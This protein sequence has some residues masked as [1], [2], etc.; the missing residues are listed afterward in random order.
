MNKMSKILNCVLLAV[1]ILCSTHNNANA[2]LPIPPMPGMP[3]LDIPANA[4]KLISNI[5]SNLRQIQSMYGQIKSG[6]LTNVKIGGL[7]F[8]KL[9]DIKGLAEKAKGGVDG[10]GGVKG[11]GKG[12]KTTGK[13]I[14]LKAVDLGISDKSTNEEEYFNAFHTLFIQLP[15]KTS[16]IKDEYPI[17][18]S[19]Y[20]EKRTDYL[21]DMIVDTY[22]TAKK[23]EEMLKV[24]EKTI[25]RLNECQ[26][27]T[28]EGAEC[29]FWG[30]QVV[31]VD[32]EAASESEE[33]CDP[34]ADE[35]C[36]SGAV[37]ESMNAYIVS[38]VYDR[39]L[40]I[41]ED[42]T[43]MEAVYKASRELN[44][45]EPVAEDAEQSSSAEDYIL[46]GYKFAYSQTVDYTN[47]KINLSN[48][49][50]KVKRSDKCRKNGKGCPAV[51]KDSTETASMDSTEVYSK[52]Q[53]IDDLLNEAI[54]YHNLKVEL[55]KYKTAY[56]KYL[57]SKAIH[58]E[59]LKV[60]AKSDQCV[61]DFLNKYKAQD[62]K[63][64]TTEL[65]YGGLFKY[66]GNSVNNHDKRGGVSRKIIEAYQMHTTDTLIGTSQKCKGFYKNCPSGYILDKENSCE[67]DETLHPCI[68]DMVTKDIGGSAN[69][70]PEVASDYENMSNDGSAYDETDGLKDGNAVD[71][72]DKEN[73]K[74]S[75]QAWR[76][77][78]RAVTELAKKGVLNFKQW[79]DQKNIQ[80]EYLTNKYR[81][82]RMIIRSTDKALNSYKIGVALTNGFVSQSEP[83]DDLLK[84]I[85]ST[86]SVEEA[87]KDG[88]A[89]SYATSKGLCGGT[90][91]VSQ[92]KNKAVKNVSTSY[93]CQKEKQVKNPVTG[94]IE[95]TKYTTT[96][97]DSV[98][99]KCEVFASSTDGYVGVRYDKYQTG[100]Q[101]NVTTKTIKEAIDLRIKNAIP[102]QG[103][104][105][106][107]ISYDDLKTALSKSSN[108][109]SCPNG[110]D[111]TVASIVQNF[112]PSVL[113][114][115]QK[116]V[117][118]QA[119]NL[120]LTA[121]GKNRVVAQDMLNAV[122]EVRK[123]EEAKMLTFIKTYNDEVEALRNKRADTLEKRVKWNKKIDE[124]TK[125][126]NDIVSM[127]KEAT[128]QV[129]GIDA[130]I[131]LLNERKKSLGKD[132][133]KDISAIN[134]SIINLGVLRNCITSDKGGFCKMCDKIKVS[135]TDKGI[136]D[137]AK[138]KE[139]YKNP[140]IST[141]KSI[142][143]DDFDLGLPKDEVAS[144]KMAVFINQTEAKKLIEAEQKII[145]QNNSYIDSTKD[146]VKKIDEELTE[147]AEIFAEDYIEKAE[148]MQE[149]IEAEN[150]K[151]E[152]FVA[153]D[154][155]RM[156]YKN[157]YV[158]EDDLETTITKVLS[159]KKLIDFIKQQINEKWFKELKTPTFAELNLPSK[160]VVGEVI[161]V[162]ENVKLFAGT[163]ESLGSI[164]ES[165]K[166]Q[167]INIAAKEIEG[168]IE[169]SD[170]I[171]STEMEA[172]IKEVNDWSGNKLCLKGEGEAET[173]P[174]CIE[175]KSEYDYMMATN[176]MKPTNEIQDQPEQEDS[177]FDEIEEK[178]A[179]ERNGL[180]TKGHIELI[181]KLKEP[182]AENKVILDSAGIN[183]QDI[184]GIPNT[185]DTD[186]LYF[187]GL[188]ARGEKDTENGRDYM[189]PK[190]PLSALPPLREVFFFSAADYHDVAKVDGGPTI[191]TLLDYK[192]EDEK[193]EYIPEVWRYI[194]ARPNLRN[195]GKYQ[196]TFIERAYGKDKLFNYLEGFDNKKART[197]VMRGGIYPCRLEQSTI[198][199]TAEFNKK[200][201][202]TGMVY[203]KNSN[204]FDNNKCQDV[205][206]TQNRIKHLL[207]DDNGK[208]PESNTNTEAFGSGVST[209][210][211]DEYSE[212]A[213]FVY[214]GEVGKRRKKRKALKYRDIL[215]LSYDLLLNQSTSAQVNNVNRQQAETT[216]FKRNVMGS[217]LEN[218][219]KEVGTRKSLEQ[220]E[221][222]IKDSLKV[223]CQQ[224]HEF[225]E[226]VANESEL[227]EDEARQEACALHIMKNR[228]LATSAEDENY[229]TSS[230][231]KM[232][233]SA[234]YYDK[235]ACKLDEMKLAKL[236][237]AKAEYE[238]VKTDYA[239]DLS[240]IQE[241]ID[242]INGYIAALTADSEEFVNIN[243]GDNGNTVK[244][245]LNK[246]K[247]DREA[248][249][250]SDNKAILSMGNQTRS[251]AY[252]PIY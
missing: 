218:V 232:N 244:S 225:G 199:V 78:S 71:N 40:R 10:I 48:L 154:D 238:K 69:S 140:H 221:Q 117:S 197:L 198:D 70:D 90:G 16:D 240:K 180:I 65:W 62:S 66:S 77:G 226:Y 95:K 207:A 49:L 2:F 84:K 141:L 155:N 105:R 7:D 80:E 63:L 53:P 215:A 23:N 96:C 89:I 187:V 73:R 43:A 104:Q 147:K 178:Q 97:Y 15:E 94:K 204:K 8:S 12:K 172:A 185:V 224:M 164:I 131:V 55:P 98:E 108:V 44:L 27:G 122:I 58:E 252:C 72:I 134:E 220:S 88:S 157:G 142:K 120:R 54:L 174:T 35:E 4:N 208:K 107:P 233:S 100:T 81:N 91:F 24:V 30:M 92:G 235:F 31:K 86:K 6:K 139:C 39:L 250:A 150:K 182:T 103:F 245:A 46:D 123:K 136:L 47:A 34:S 175:G 29:T 153:N 110:W 124:A 26:V 60:L 188:P 236:E 68:V 222:D 144:V 75:E 82:I 200:D 76:I 170:K 42:L 176:Y 25:N 56:R 59:T 64:T 5:Q 246:A 106:T 14:G 160:V 61:V 57:K 67:D 193:F 118:L 133:V 36:N 113:G 41:V 196:Q 237:A 125:E 195:D 248:T 202:L 13:K 212:L 192:Y 249:L 74:K 20:K 156:K 211:Y 11:G 203:A 3:E 83:I 219:N 79:N 177:L 87:I 19:A 17:I 145:D 85:S 151:F 239:A 169:K 163:Y 168:A 132:K 102:Y 183:L 231:E 205:A 146:D 179:D 229:T 242:E 135:Y 194:L 21:Q 138:R 152:L 115:C 50:S 18:E 184:F 191:S 162:A 99:L 143:L 228:G 201:Q 230:C 93:S 9:K 111:F 129:A 126:K 158:K 130:E 161:D 186:T 52:L 213:Q 149:N 119:E 45:V 206:L 38:T 165:L 33:E 171:I 128:S 209:G 121:Q 247:A 214:I 148:E 223:L 216:S 28:K 241:R 210:I 1:A 166:D 167:I 37:G 190:E 181:E 32:P 101:N 116:D 159:D 51:N 22:L 234:T 251:V 189:A 227:S 127:E 109:T 114:G 112:M 243:P 137:D 173:N 217:F